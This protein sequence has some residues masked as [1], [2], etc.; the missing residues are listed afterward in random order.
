MRDRIDKYTRTK[1][2]CWYSSANTS[3]YLEP[4]SSPSS[5]SRQAKEDVSNGA[6]DK[7]THKEIV[8][9]ARCYAL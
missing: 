6:E 2:S 9:A 7:S 1:P 5:S 3:E 4:S 8:P